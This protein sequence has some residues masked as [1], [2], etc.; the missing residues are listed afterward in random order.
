MQNYLSHW[1]VQ[2]YSALFLRSTF[3]LEMAYYFFVNLL[4]LINS[5][6]SQKSLQIGLPFWFYV[7]IIIIWSIHKVFWIVTHIKSI[8]LGVRLNKQCSI[9]KWSSGFSILWSFVGKLSLSRRGIQVKVFT[10]YLNLILLLNVVL[11]ERLWETSSQEKIILVL[12]LLV[13][14]DTSEM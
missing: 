1:K 3:K 8:V 10:I 4:R 12:Y 7:R 6:M 5:R 11:K 9:K 13:L 14:L 2:L